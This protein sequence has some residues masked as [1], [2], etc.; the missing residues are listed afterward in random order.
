MADF[1]YAGLADLFAVE[2]F[3]AA[4]T[5]DTGR[6]VSSSGATDSKNGSDPSSGKSDSRSDS[7][8]SA[9]V[10]AG[11]VVGVIA[12]AALI[13]AVV[14]LL[15]RRRRS[16][17]A[18]LQHNIEDT[19]VREQTYCGTDGHSVL[20]GDG[21]RTEMPGQVPPRPEVVGSTPQAELPAWHRYELS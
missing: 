5:D 14:F 16:K 12:G 4:A 7:E 2:N 9:S 6:G 19:G 15:L 20:Y 3:T 21:P 13:G 18:K 11:S 17:R 1:T 8:S 10:I